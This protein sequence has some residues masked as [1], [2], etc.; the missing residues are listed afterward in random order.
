M[1]RNMIKFK[2]EINNRVVEIE[3][4]IDEDNNITRMGVPVYCTC[5]G[6]TRETGTQLKY[7]PNSKIVYCPSCANSSIEVNTFDDYQDLAVEN[8][9]LKYFGT[10]YLTLQDLYK[11]SYTLPYEKWILISEY[12]MKLSPD[13]VDLGDFK[14][15]FV[16]WVTSNPSKVEEILGVKDELRV[17]KE[18]QQGYDK[19]I[20]IEVLNKL[21]EE[22]SMVETPKPTGEDGK[23]HLDGEVIDNPF[24]PRN[25]YGG[26]EWFVITD[27]YVWFVRNNSRDTDNWSFNNVYVKGS[28]GAIGKRIPVST[29]VVDK[30]YQLKEYGDSLRKLNYI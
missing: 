12:F 8:I 27:E 13:M 21:L 15:Q 22:F 10:D 5:T 3:G 29:D 24:N 20:L 17:T 18:N 4:K 26:G 9:H 19:Q 14:P 7:N 11:L 16:G 6:N 25:I 28:Y 2:I 30:V 23:F 1:D